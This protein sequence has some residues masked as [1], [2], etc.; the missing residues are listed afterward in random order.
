MDFDSAKS[1]DNTPGR[2]R[3]FCRAM[4]ATIS[5]N[6]AQTTVLDGYQRDAGGVERNQ[7]VFRQ[8][9]ERASPRNRTVRYTHHQ[10]V[11]VRDC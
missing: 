4:V 2:V 6:S 11:R 8:K 7:S 1:E 10:H 9:R 3:T 5:G